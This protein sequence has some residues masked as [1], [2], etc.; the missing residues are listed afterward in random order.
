MTVDSFQYTITL[1]IIVWPAQINGVDT[2]LFALCF[3]TSPTISSH[4]PAQ[5]QVNSKPSEPVISS[6]MTTPPT[7]STTA[8][9]G[10]ESP[11]ANIFHNSP[12]TTPTKKDSASR[13]QNKVNI[14]GNLP[15]SKVHILGI[16]PP[17]VR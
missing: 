4:L 5:Q 10:G 13:P 7:N 12:Y 8:M 3:S 16:S 11:R 14:P 17:R 6:I 15:Q 1:A 2:D 9:S